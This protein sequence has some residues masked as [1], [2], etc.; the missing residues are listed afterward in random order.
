MQHVMDFKMR[1]ACDTGGTF[2]D[3]IVEDGNCLKMYKASTTPRDPVEGVLN[4]L[5]LAAANYNLPLKTFLA[6]ADT[7][8]HATTRSINAIL[9]GNIA[10]TAFFTTEGHKDILVLREGGRI[11]PFNFTQE[12][13]EPFAAQSLT[14]AIPERPHCNGELVRQLD[15]KK[16]I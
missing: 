4:A 1:L 10:K 2:T 6:Q 5:E 12:Y 8:V 16:R 13:P 15:E 14:F 3:L 11:E 7:F 9:T